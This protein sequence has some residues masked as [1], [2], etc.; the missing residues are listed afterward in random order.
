MTPNIPD[1]EAVLGQDEK[2]S[3]PT[4][5]REEPSPSTPNGEGR[6]RTGVQTEGGFAAIEELLE[7]PLITSHRI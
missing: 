1:A 3:Q 4:D 6:I 5:Q 2:R 7:R